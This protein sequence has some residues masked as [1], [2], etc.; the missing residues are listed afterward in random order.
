MAQVSGTIWSNPVTRTTVA[1]VSFFSFFLRA[2]RHW[3]GMFAFSAAFAAGSALA[4]CD[5]PKQ[6]PHPA[7]QTHPADQPQPGSKQDEPKAAQP[8]QKTPDGEKPKTDERK[9]AATDN[10]KP[11]TA[12]PKPKIEV[13]KELPTTEA[14]IA[15]RVFKLEIASTPD[16]RRIGLMGRTSIAETGGMVFVFPASEFGVQ[17]FWM[18]DCQTEMDLVFLDNAGRVLKT[19]EMK[20]PDPP[21]TGQDNLDYENSLKRYS[22]IFPSG[23]AIELAP[24]MVKKLG[25]KEGDLVK[26]DV[27]ALKKSAK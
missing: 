7:P 15:G 13:N 26:L 2:V 11:S 18:K 8:S 17:R 24:G 16:T 10:A 25:L 5:E 6:A 22:S 21:K 14:T 12:D 1:P 27:Q 9:P 4:G 23:L 20:V 3:V 19:H